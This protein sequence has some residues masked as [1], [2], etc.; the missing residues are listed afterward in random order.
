MTAGAPRGCL[1][2]GRRGTSSRVGQRGLTGSRATGL[3]ETCSFK[4]GPLKYLKGL[5]GDTLHHSERPQPWHNTTT[6]RAEARARTQTHTHTKRQTPTFTD[7]S[8]WHKQRQEA[9]LHLAI[10]FTLTG[11]QHI[12]APLECVGVCVC[13]CVCVCHWRGPYISLY[14]CNLYL[15]KTH[16]VSGSPR[17]CRGGKE[18]WRERFDAS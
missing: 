8:C 5:S 14:S 4:L 1:R 2:E 6:H 10:H 15:N 3:R 13:V 16:T 11:V 9:P 12:K 17:R 7:P 18:R